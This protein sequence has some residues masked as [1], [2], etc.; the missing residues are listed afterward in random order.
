MFDFGEQLWNVNLNPKEVKCFG[1]VYF[2]SDVLAV[3]PTG[4]GESIVFDLAASPSSCFF[5]CHLPTFWE[6]RDQPAPGSFFPRS[7]WGDERFR[8]RGWRLTA[9][10]SNI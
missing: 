3:L 4:Y 7:L 10:C 8:E 1:A 9:M 2:G 5:S 6:T